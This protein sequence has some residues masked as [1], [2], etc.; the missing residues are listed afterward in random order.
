MYWSRQSFG[1]FPGMPGFIA[2]TIGVN[3]I[4]II[5]FP[6]IAIGMLVLSNKKKLDGKI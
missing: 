1:P 5:G 6:V 3:A 2:L 4:N